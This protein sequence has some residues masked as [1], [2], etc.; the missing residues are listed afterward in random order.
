MNQIIKFLGLFGL[1]FIFSC[2]TGDEE[3]DCP[4]LGLNYGDLCVFSFTDREETEGIVSDDC[5]CI[6]EDIDLQDERDEEEH[7]EDESEGRGECFEL[8]YPVSL[9]LPDGTSENADN[10]DELEIIFNDWEEANPNSDQEPEFIYPIQVILYD[11]DEIVDVPSEEGLERIYNQCEN[12]VDDIDDDIDGGECFSLV[13]P[14][15]V[16]LPNGG[17]EVAEDEEGLE[18][19]YE[20][21]FEV[22]PNSNQEPQLVFP[23]QVI[24]E[25]ADRSIEVNS[26]EELERLYS[27]CN[28]E[29]NDDEY[30]CF[31][32]VYPIGVTLPDGMIIRVPDHESLE[33]LYERWANANPNSDEEPTLIFPLQILFRDSDIPID[34]DSEATLERAFERCE[35]NDDKEDCFDLVFPVG[36]SLPNGTEVRAEDEESLER[37]YERWFTAYPDS[38]KEPSLLFPIQIIIDGVDSPVVVSSDEDLDRIYERCENSTG[39]NEIDCPELGGDIGDRCRLDDGTAGTITIECTCE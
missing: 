21:W 3:L 18:T 12:E 24:F 14:L 25:T 8:V 27:R 7:N 6:S 4:E 5:E 34:I 30:D 35:L 36:I 17:T 15:E 20:K 19:I 11:N 28:D 37:I 26:D 33:A 16:L 22:N 23:V 38:Q 2:G 39:G 9:F 10:E 1:V 13:Y 29:G 31:E 32:F